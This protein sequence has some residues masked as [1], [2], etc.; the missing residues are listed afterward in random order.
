MNASKLIL[1]AGLFAFITAKFS[2][3][4]VTPSSAQNTP[5]PTATVADHLNTEVPAT[6][7]VTIRTEIERG[8]NAAPNEVDFSIL[9]YNDAVKAVE[10]RNKQKNTDSKPFQFGLNYAAWHELW[11]SLSFG[12]YRSQADRNLAEVS[13][14]VFFVL[15]MAYQKNLG[16]SDDD[17]RSVASVTYVNDESAIFPEI[18]KTKN[19]R[20]SYPTYP[21]RPKNRR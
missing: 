1:L 7:R 8:M 10:D 12:V 15:T 21:S 18:L 4:Q 6:T 14:H 16:L 9:N 17:I 13:A 20:G 5:T 11:R 2:P 3:A 19:F